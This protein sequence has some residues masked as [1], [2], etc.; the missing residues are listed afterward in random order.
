[1]RCPSAYCATS[2]GIAITRPGA[3]APSPTGPTAARTRLHSV[4]RDRLFVGL[5]VRRPISSRSVFDRSSQ[6]AA[7]G[8]AWAS[9]EAGS[10]APSS[11]S[12]DVGL[13]L[14]WRGRHQ[15]LPRHVGP[16]RDDVRQHVDFLVLLDP[17]EARRSPDG[18]RVDVQIAECGRDALR[19]QFRER[20]SPV[21]AARPYRRGRAAGAR[22]SSPPRPTRVRTRRNSRRRCRISRRSPCLTVA[23]GADCKG[24]SLRILSVAGPTYASPITGRG[25]G[26]AAAARPPAT[27]RPRC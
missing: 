19:R 6:F 17:Q 13:L 12:S 26:R 22:P 8:A 18:L 16:R 5:L 4:R 24:M 25:A 3:S 7:A 23:T 21:P 2:S 1:M 10:S 27:A 11:A 15:R 9:A 14:L 20:A